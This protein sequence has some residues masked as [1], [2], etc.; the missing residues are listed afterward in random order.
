MKKKNKRGH[1]ILTQNNLK[2]HFHDYNCL[3]I[4]LNCY[5][6]MYL[7]KEIKHTIYLNIA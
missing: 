7:G 5:L 6:V 4:I 3:Q 1:R 2:A